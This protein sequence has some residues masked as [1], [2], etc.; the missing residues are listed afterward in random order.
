M[1]CLKWEKRSTRETLSSSV[2][3]ACSRLQ[4]NHGSGEIQN[5]CMGTGGLTRVDWIEACVCLCEGVGG[6]GGGVRVS[7]KINQHGT[8][9]AGKKSKIFSQN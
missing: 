4:E 3:V 2:W 1:V 8:L 6:G 9:W 7:I 5:A